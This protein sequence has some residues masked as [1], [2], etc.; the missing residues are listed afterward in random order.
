MML[1]KFLFPA[2]LVT[3][4]AMG[5]VPVDAAPQHGGGGG[6]HGASGSGFHGGGAGGFHGGGSGGTHSGGGG[7]F[8]GGGMVHGGGF[9]GRG[10]NGHGGFHG[11]HGFHGRG[12]F[13]GGGF[14]HGFGPGFRFRPRFGLGFGVILGYPFAYPYYDPLDYSFYPVGP[15]VYDATQ[16]Y[17]GVSFSISP[18]YATVTVDGTYAGTVDQFNDPA[19][20]LTLPPGQHRLVIEAPGYSTLDIAVAVDAGQVIPYEGDLQPN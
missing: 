18:G 15:W 8:H 19:H 2:A 9:H 10:M 14:H 16:G 12:E 20:P 5:A 1:H 6:S 3:M 7:G 17:G 13:H 11:D 4:F